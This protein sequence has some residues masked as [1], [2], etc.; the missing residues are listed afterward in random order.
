MVSPLFRTAC[1]DK[2]ATMILS[3]TTFSTA[4][5][6]APVGRNVWFQSRGYLSASSFPAESKSISLKSEQGYCDVVC[7]RAPTYRPRAVSECP[8]SST[9]IPSHSVSPKLHPEAIPSRPSSNHRVN[10]GTG[11]AAAHDVS[12]QTTCAS[13][14]R[15]GV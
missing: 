6:S 13:L 2:S 10:P 7:H 14:R 12:W 4:P 8:R 3:W 5:P 15:I 1:V 11:R 9:H